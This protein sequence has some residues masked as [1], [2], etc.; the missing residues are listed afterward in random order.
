MIGSFWS[1][2]VP[3]HNEFIALWLLIGFLIYFIVTLVMICSRDKIYVFRYH[4]DYEQLFLYTFGVIFCLMCT[5][6]YILFYSASPIIKKELQKLDYTGKL[7]F[8]HFLLLAY[9]ACELT[10][11]TLFYAFLFLTFVVLAVNVVII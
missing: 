10:S 6:A 4:Q 7:V 2:F 9:I 8:I 5:I 1:L 3:W 11:S